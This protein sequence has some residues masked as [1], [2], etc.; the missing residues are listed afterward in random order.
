MAEQGK[1]IVVG[2]P[3]E[4]FPGERRV[5]LIADVIPTVIKSGAEVLVESGAGVGAGIMDESYTRKGAKIVS[6]DEIF[7]KSDVIFQVRTFG[8]NPDAGRADLGKVRQGQIVIGLTESLSD[9]ALSKEFARCGGSVFS[10]ELVPRI[11]RAQ[12]MDVLSSMATIAGYKAIILAAEVL[13]KFFPMFMTAAG[14]IAPARVFIV[15]VGVAGL[16]AISTAKRLGAVVSAYDIRPAV[17]DQVKSVGAKFVELELEAGDAE[18]KGGYA[19]AMGEEFYRKQREMMTKIVKEHDV[20]VT[21]AAVP[22]KKA[23]IL[24]TEEMVKGMI[25]GSV[26]VDLAAERGGNCELTRPGETIQAHGVTIMGPLNLP[27]TV[28]YHASQMYS[29][30]ITAFFQNMVK[31]GAINLNMEDEIIRDTLITRGGEIVSPRIKELLGVSQ[32]GV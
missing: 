19:K 3:K 27:A 14:T 9:P 25:P 20:V 12:S 16:Q 7:A 31:D 32:A 17:K 2:V 21:T 15:G 29:K 8:A 10:L 5:A 4:T 18:D 23:P 24:V 1:P 6:R 11:T 30:N 13:P 26:I 28:S 22:G